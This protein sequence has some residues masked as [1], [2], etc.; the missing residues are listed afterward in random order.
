MRIGFGYDVH[1]IGP[2]RPLVLGGV[3]IGAPF[4]LVGHS[5]ADVIAHAVM[6]AMLGALA[7]G[8][9]GVHFPLAMRRIVERTVW[10]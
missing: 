7:L 9:I 3:R 8:D 10:T 2:D 5:D 4:G 6:D 1:P